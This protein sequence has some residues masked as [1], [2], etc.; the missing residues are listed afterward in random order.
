VVLDTPMNPMLRDAEQ[1]PRYARAHTIHREFLAELSQSHHVPLIVPNDVIAY[2]P[3]DF[4]DYGHLHT[5][6]AMQDVTAYMAER[7]AEII[8]SGG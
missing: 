7:L 4:H 3:A 5:R 8:T 6:K 1:R 2:D